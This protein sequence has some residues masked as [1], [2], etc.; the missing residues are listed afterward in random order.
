MDPSTGKFVIGVGYSLVRGALKRYFTCPNNCGVFVAFTKLSPPTVALTFRPSSVA[1]SRSGRI[2]PSFSGR[3]TPSA[4]ISLSSG[5]VTPSNS[6]SGI[7][8]YADR[9]NHMAMHSRITP[10]LTPSAGKLKQ[11]QKSSATLR[12]DFETQIT[13]GS[14]ASR[15]VGLTAKQLSSRSPGKESLS[16]GSSPR[17]PSSPTRTL[18][19]E[20]GLSA[21][22]CTTP[23]A[24]AASGHTNA[25]DG[26]ST[27]GVKHRP[28]LNTPRPRIP[29][30]VAMPPPQSPAQRSSSPDSY[31]DISIQNG[32]LS[33]DNLSAPLN[34]ITQSLQGEASP[35]LAGDSTTT[36]SILNSV[37]SNVSFPTH[38]ADTATL[39]ANLDNL[40]QEVVSLQNTVASLLPEA[41]QR[42]SAEKERDAALSSM[43]ET[44]KELRSLE[45][46]FSEKDSK[47][48]ALERSHSQ[49][50]AELERV[51][52]ESE[53]RMNDLQAK[54]DTNEAL[55]KSLKEAIQHKEGAEH[56]SDALLKAKNAEITL[57]Q[58]RLE[59]VSSELDMER[60][61]LGGQIDELRQAGQVNT[62]ILRCQSLMDSI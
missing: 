33:V 27:A 58:G 41:Q 10:C 54:L 57:L 44:E 42:I 7:T 32:R 16:A 24:R 48:E 50:T 18:D 37:S 62:V 15:Y 45:R 5:R 17:P 6:I 61:E 52:A 29:S 2:T 40:Q 8:P 36:K 9:K 60:R 49:T 47:C 56:E 46:R 20:P 19:S 3:I 22:T 11:S 21:L 13:S 35:R 38:E 28:S 55:V 51:K 12:P 4:S 14:R 43:A 25:I 59:K 34:S 30:A 31:N 53:A 1:S 39:N 26:A 23:K